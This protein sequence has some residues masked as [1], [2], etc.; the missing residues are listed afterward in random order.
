MSTRVRARY[1]D[2][3]LTPLEPLDLEEGC[4]IDM[5]L[6]LPPPAAGAEED[7]PLAQ[8]LLR[9]REE[10]HAQLPPEA[11]EGPPTDWSLNYKHYLYGHPKQEVE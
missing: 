2:G 7:E 6:E 3:V 11:F 4:E 9:L 5:S 1:A 8:R 10:L